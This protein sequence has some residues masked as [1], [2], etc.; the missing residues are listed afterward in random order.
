M[1]FKDLAINALG[2][3]DLSVLDKYDFNVYYDFDEFQAIFKSSDTINDVIE[4]IFEDYKSAIIDKYDGLISEEDIEYY[5]NY[6]DSHFYYKSC[7]ITNFDDLEEEIL[8]NLTYW[9]EHLSLEELQ[10]ITDKPIYGDINENGNEEYINECDDWFNQHTL[11]E[12]MRIFNEF[13]NN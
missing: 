6:A 4:K 2:L 12:K 1:D 5:V 11:Y 9:W 10:K 7:S 8:S 3:N 13:I